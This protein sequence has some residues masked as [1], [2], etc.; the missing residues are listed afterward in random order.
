MTS[1]SL[2]QS[3]DWWAIAPPVLLAVT[4][5]AALLGDLLTATKSW[6]A[7]LSLA[8]VVTAATALATGPGR[9]ASS[10]CLLEADQL[11][12]C[13]YRVT[14]ATLVLQGLLLVAGAVLVLLSARTVAARDLPAGE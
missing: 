4:A 8:G 6:L 1:Q 11:P 2:V 13:A 3:V 7:W 12:S 5:L 14:T 10:F 9:G